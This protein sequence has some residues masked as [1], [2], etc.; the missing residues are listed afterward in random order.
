MQTELLA[1]GGTIVLALVHIFWAGHARTRQYGTRWNI[2]ARDEEMPPLAPLP[3]RLLR[4]QA[5]FMETFPLFAAALL[6]AIAAG[7]IGWKTALG[8]QLYLAGRLAYLP[9]YAAGVTGWRTLA[10]MV[11]LAGLLLVLWALLFG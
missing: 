2:G 9:L 6:G 7:H 3:G 10:F 4:A 1:L 11:S 5:N 8:A